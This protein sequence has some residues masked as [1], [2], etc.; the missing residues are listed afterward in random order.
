MAVMTEMN[1]AAD[2]EHVT[3][4]NEIRTYG[5]MAPPGFGD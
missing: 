1:P 4:P 5:V 2:I 3:D